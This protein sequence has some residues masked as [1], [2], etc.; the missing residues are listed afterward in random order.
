M[1]LTIAPQFPQ[2][3]SVAWQKDDTKGS[4]PGKQGNT[5]GYDVLHTCRYWRERNNNSST[6][7]GY[8]CNQT[9]RYLPNPSVL[10]RS[11]AAYKTAISTLID[12]FSVDMIGWTCGSCAEFICNVHADKI[13]LVHYSSSSAECDSLCMIV[14]CFTCQCC[15]N[16][17]F[18][19]NER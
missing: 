15:Y 7:H 11:V 9:P 12:I 3:S 13:E 6:E 2:N 4:S 17:R 5:L 1:P 10:I 16:W 19:T 14:I 18:W 8:E